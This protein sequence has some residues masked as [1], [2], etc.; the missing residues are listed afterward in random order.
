MVELPIGVGSGPSL[1][2]GCRE[3]KSEWGASLG[4]SCR[5]WASRPVSPRRRVGKD[6]PVSDDTREKRAMAPGIS[7]L[8]V[9]V[10]VVVVAAGMQRE[11]HMLV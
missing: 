9:V 11:E 2:P 6:Q 10:V 4:A 1:V 5:S 3:G 7:V 8:V